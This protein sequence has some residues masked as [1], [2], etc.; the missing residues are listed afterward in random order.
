MFTNVFNHTVILLITTNH[1][2]SINHAVRPTIHSINGALEV[3]QGHSLRLRCE[4]DPLSLVQ[5]LFRSTPLKSSH[6]KRIEFQDGG[7]TLVVHFTTVSDAG[8]LLLL[9]SVL[10]LLLL[11]LSVLFLLFLLLLLSV[12]MLLFLLLSIVIIIVF[13]MVVVFIVVDFIFCVY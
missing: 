9:F 1:A 13:V 6:D 11:L 5:W 12:L 4:V 3:N 10:L 2:K 8:R 7:I